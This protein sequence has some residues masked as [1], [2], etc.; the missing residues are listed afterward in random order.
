MLGITQKKMPNNNKNCYYHW[1][2][3]LSFFRFSVRNDDA[4]VLLKRISVNKKK[5]KKNARK[6]KMKKGKE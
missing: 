4:K 3:F 5:K 1:P 2:F 6:N